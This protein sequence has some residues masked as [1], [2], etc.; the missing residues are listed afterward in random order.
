MI[1]IWLILIR[2]HMTNKFCRKSKRFHQFFI[3]V[4]E[5]IILPILDELF[6]LG[7]KWQHPVESPTVVACILQTTFLIQMTRKG[8]N[9]EPLDI[10]D[11]SQ[12]LRPQPESLADVRHNVE[13]D[14]LAADDLLDVLL[15]LKVTSD[16]TYQSG[17]CDSK[18]CLHFILIPVSSKT[19]L[20]AQSSKLSS[21]LIFPFGN[22]QH[23]L[24]PSV[25]VEIN[26]ENGSLTLNEENLWT[27]L[28]QNNG[29][30]GGYRHLVFQPAL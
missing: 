14:W 21:S 20:T 2:S 22:P 29:T 7:Y 30:K 26:L 25:S 3:L 1:L 16:G 10:L 12:T 8:G 18:V 6:Q 4:P 15:G 24:T 13:A 17:E 28:V 23:P 11:L 5:V 19:S 27:G 9:A